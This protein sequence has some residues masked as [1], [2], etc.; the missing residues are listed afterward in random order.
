MKAFSGIVQEVAR[1]GDTTLGFGR[2]SFD[3]WCIYV[4][5]GDYQKFPLDEWYFQILLDWTEHSDAEFIYDDF[6]KIYDKTTQ[7]V[8]QEVLDEIRALSNDY[9]DP[10]HT[11]IIFTIL[12]MGM[13]AEENKA[14]AI[15][16]KR[17][18]R[19]GVYQVLIEGVQPR[20]AANYSRGLGADY[21]DKVCYYRGF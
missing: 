2:G 16:K 4:S 9:P 12:Y 19:L 15:L 11:A 8:A 21:L 6:V 10:E 3:D 5:G 18:K 14:N 1:Y 17:I 7:A 13:I 20:V